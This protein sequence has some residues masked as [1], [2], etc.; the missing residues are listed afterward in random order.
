[1]AASEWSMESLRCHRGEHQYRQQL[2][3]AVRSSYLQLLLRR[4][5]KTVARKSCVARL[6]YFSLRQLWGLLHYLFSNGPE[7][8]VVLAIPRCFTVPYLLRGQSLA[9]LRT[10]SLIAVPEAIS[11]APL[12]RSSAN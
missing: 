7:R 6:A 8:A 3:F 2:P 10:S 5:G 12:R 1:V 9:M 4:A 11:W